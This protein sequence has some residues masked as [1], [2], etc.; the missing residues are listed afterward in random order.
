MVRRIRIDGLRH[1][2]FLFFAPP[3]SIQLQPWSR[4][5]HGRVQ[6]P[7]HLQIITS[8]RPQSRLGSNMALIP[9]EASLPPQRSGLYW[10][11]LSRHL[12]SSTL[13]VPKLRTPLPQ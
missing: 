6:A 8:W 5:F 7:N 12:S 11:L 4:L 1:V 9:C 2:V 10:S 3:D 13:I